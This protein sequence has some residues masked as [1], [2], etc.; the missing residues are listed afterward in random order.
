MASH[1]IK[2]VGVGGSG[3]ATVERMLGAGGCDLIAVHTDAVSLL[4]H[5]ADAKIL[6]GLNV[7]KGRSTGNNI[8]L[9]EEAA[10]ADR[11][12][13]REVLGDPEVAFVIAGLGG[14]TGAGASPI[15]AE[16]AKTHGATVVAFVNIPFTAEGRVC[17]SNALT[18]LD[19]LKPYCDLIVVIQN[20]RFLKVVPDLSI[21]D[22]FTK[23]NH[24]VLE[25]VRG[26]VKLVMESGTE[27][28][29]PLL[30]GYATIG[31]GVGP[32]LKKAVE[33]ALDSPLVGADLS[34]AQGVLVNFTTHTKALKGVGAALNVISQGTNGSAGVIW[35][36]TV[37]DSAEGVEV[38]VVFAGVN[39]AL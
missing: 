24:M 39:P 31:H 8:R 20:D 16:T 22:A 21:R 38:L 26:M 37:D 2:V 4:E 13:I 14:G 15:V 18:G 19:N 17:K 9:G 30:G 5:K 6:I 28:L 35:T 12:K 23:V 33:A 32:T 10:I 25:A 34:A 11:D 3:C 36:N 29:K 1:V 7:T 27:N